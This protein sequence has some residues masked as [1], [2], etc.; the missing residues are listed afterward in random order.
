MPKITIRESDLTQRRFINDV[1]NAVYIP[2]FAS[3]GINMASQ[4]DDYIISRNSV[5]GVPVGVPKLCLSL[6]EFTQYFGEEIPAFEQQQN[7]PTYDED[8]PNAQGG[9]SPVALSGLTSGVMFKQNEYDPSYVMAYELIKQGIPVIYERVNYFYGT[10]SRGGQGAP[11]NTT[12]GFIGDI[13]LDKS[14]DIGDEPNVYICVD[15]DN[16]GLTS[17]ERYTNYHCAAISSDISIERMYEFLST[18]FKETRDGQP[19]NL[20][21]KNEYDIKYITTGGYPVFEYVTFDAAQSKYTKN[22]I[23]KDILYLCETSTSGKRDS[24][25]GLLRNDCIGLIDHINNPVRKLTGT[26]SV[27]DA[28]NNGDYSLTSECAAMFTPYFLYASTVGNVYMPASF[29]YLISLAEMV[30]T[31]DNW[32]AVAGVARGVVPGAIRL[33]TVQKLTNSIA[34]SFVSDLG[35][36][37]IN[38]ITNIRNYGLTIWGNRTLATTQA[39]TEKALYYLN[40]RSLINEVKKVCYRASQRLMFEQNSDVL[41]INFK[42]YITPLLDRMQSSAGISGYKIVKE[43]S[44]RKTEVKASIK[45]YPIYAVESFDISV[46]L[47]NEEV[48]VEEE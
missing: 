28:I 15:V 14:E 7:Y 35:G 23:A 16:D 26:G 46:V 10:A 25:E 37:C 33:N 2:G 44:E 32:L 21:D 9:F 38:P 43:P 41:W 13:Y 39:D 3:A 34:D 11:T 8:Y 24:S 17:W 31:S 22:E 27:Y 5:N 29:A 4:F 36:I 1:M 6:A 20:F 47:T 30:K 12:P 40:M 42:S 19:N 48:S 18:A 45:L